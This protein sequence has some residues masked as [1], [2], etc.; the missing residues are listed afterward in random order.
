M[1]LFST[2]AIIVASTIPMTATPVLAAAPVVKSS[3]SVYREISALLDPL[4]MKVQGPFG[5][6]ASDALME[7]DYAA[8]VAILATVKTL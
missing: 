1:K 5:D 8:L 3:M 6:E 7:D 2:A 4:P